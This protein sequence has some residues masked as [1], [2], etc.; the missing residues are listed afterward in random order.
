MHPVF[1]FEYEHHRLEL[2]FLFVS[3]SLTLSS[4]LLV[5]LFNQD[6]LEQVDCSMI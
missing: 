5:L 4:F 1:L 2:R 3:L 6:P